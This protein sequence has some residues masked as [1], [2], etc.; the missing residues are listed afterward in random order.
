MPMTYLEVVP[1]YG[2][3]YRSAGAAKADWKR[4]VDFLET[5]TNRY[6]SKRDVERDPSLHVIIRYNQQ[7]FVTGAP[8]N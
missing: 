5:V 3:D 1:A 7:R 6:M 8:T 4:G 2:R